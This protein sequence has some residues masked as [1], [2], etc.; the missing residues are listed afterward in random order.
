MT[1]TRTRLCLWVAVV[2]SALT[3]LSAPAPAVA[4]D[5]GTTRALLARGA[6]FDRPRGSAQVRALQRRLRADSVDPGPVDG[7][8]GPL[9]EAAVRRFQ[10]AR[11]LVVDGIVGPRTGPAL[12]APV[13]LARGA[14]ANAPHGSDRVR[15]L[16][17]K[18]RALGT[19]PGPLDGRFGPRTEAAVRRF[20]HAQRLAADG[21]VGPHTTRQ[22][23]RHEK[24]AATPP[25]RTTQQHPARRHTERPPAQRRP[26]IADTTKRPGTSGG[27]LDAVA[28]AAL[29]ALAVLAAA[30]LAVGGSTWRRRREQ[31][32]PTPDRDAAPIPAPA[33][34]APGPALA[35]RASG[36]GPRPTAPAHR[37]RRRGPNTGSSAQGSRDNQP[38]PDNGSSASGP[39]PSRRSDN[40]SAARATRSATAVAERPPAPE[41]VPTVRALGYVSVPHDSPLEAAAGRQAA[42]IEAACTSRGWAFIGGVRESEPANGKGLERPGLSHAL[43]RLERGEADCLVVTELARLTRSAAELGELVDRLGRARVRLVVLD[44]EIDTYT[45][46]GQ[47]VAK[48]L[49]MVSAWERERLSERTR[50]GLAAARER[51]TAGRPAVSDRPELVEKITTM[52]AS[53]MTLQAIADALNAQGEPTVRGGTHWRPSSVQAALGYKRRPKAPN[54]NGLTNPQNERQDH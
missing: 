8:F 5:T 46:S 50:K 31:R 12:R 7:R 18:L 51:G 23:A 54:P 43:A 45:N 35:A 21:I 20:Q 38:R 33:A 41:T 25:R 14:G 16:Q 1:T 17:R 39:Q 13:P 29:V 52:R 26:P 3:V 40:G 4:S 9:T 2:V 10:A 47:L 49:A 32:I 15:A 30:A 24:P 36:P 19:H 22:L 11:G 34:I 6:G 53:G 44:L 37:P 48:A 42:A 27:G 28:I